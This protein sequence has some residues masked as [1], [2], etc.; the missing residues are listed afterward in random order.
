MSYRWVCTAPS[1][2]PPYRAIRVIVSPA[3]TR[4]SSS[5]G[6][7]AQVAAAVGVA[8]ELAIPVMLPVRPVRVLRPESG[9]DFLHKPVRLPAAVEAVE[10]HCIAADLAHQVG[11]QRFRQ[12][13]VGGQVCTVLADDARQSAQVPSAGHHR[14]YHEAPPVHVTPAAPVWVSA[15]CRMAAMA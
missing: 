15:E 3:D 5:R 13:S 2:M 12:P 7:A 11:Q 4:R 6:R 14:S 10:N 8:V 1:D 9:R